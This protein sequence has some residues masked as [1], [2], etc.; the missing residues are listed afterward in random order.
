MKSWTVIAE[1]IF[2]RLPDSLTERRLILCS[3]RELLPSGHPAAPLVLQHLDL[4]NRVDL[5]Q[6][7]F[8]FGANSEV[9]IQEADPRTPGEPIAPPPHGSSFPE[10]ASDSD[11]VVIQQAGPRTPGEPIRYPRSFGRRPRAKGGAR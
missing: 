7:E 2:A 6:R 11:G 1:A 3:L 5:D 4:L 10:V 9:V 8:P